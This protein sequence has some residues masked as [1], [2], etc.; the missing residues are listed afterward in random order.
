MSHTIQTGHS[1]N[2]F[3]DDLLYHNHGGNL[4]PDA[5]RLTLNGDTVLVDLT[6]GT[7]YWMVWT[8]EETAQYLLLALILDSPEG[9]DWHF[10]AYNESG[11][12]L[13]LPG[14]TVGQQANAY[15]FYLGDSEFTP[16]TY[17]ISFVSPMT[18]EAV[19]VGF[20]TD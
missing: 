15:I 4:H 1:G 3:W 18:Q 2:Q 14:S 19:V 5:I 9:V 11:G 7:T 17:Y 6:L 20:G 8:M 12:V 13:D 16:G 10:A